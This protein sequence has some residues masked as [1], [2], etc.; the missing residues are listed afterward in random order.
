MLAER[1]AHRDA[2][3]VLKV[4]I[5]Q[6]DVGPRG[7]RPVQEVASRRHGQ[8]SISQ[9]LEHTV[10]RLVEPRP[11]VGEEHDGRASEGRPRRHGAVNVATALV[12]RTRQNPRLGGEKT[13]VRE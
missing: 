5:H 1:A 13:R 10:E 11:R 4:R 3:Q 8:D 7:G 2:I 9:R 12:G 6:D